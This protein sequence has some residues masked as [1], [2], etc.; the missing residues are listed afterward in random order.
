[1]AAY[2]I[3]AYDVTDPETYENYNPGSVPLIMETMTRHGGEVLAAGPG[4]QA[5]WGDEKRDIFV[6]LRF[7]SVEA[8]QAWEN[9]PDYAPAKAI[10]LASTGNYTEFVAPEFNP[11]E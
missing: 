3:F 4:D 8:G 10:R 11:P 6:V 2:M 9:D 7:P 1:M 5:H